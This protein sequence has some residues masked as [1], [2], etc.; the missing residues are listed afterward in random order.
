[1]NKFSECRIFEL[2]KLLHHFYGHMIMEELVFSNFLELVSYRHF[3]D[4]WRSEY[5]DKFHTTFLNV[6]P[7][8]KR[9]DTLKVADW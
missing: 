2:K 8:I 7:E 1:M 6:V 3:P 5:K 9:W 4:S